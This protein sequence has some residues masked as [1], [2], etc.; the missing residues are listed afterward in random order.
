M[1]TFF[2]IIFSV[3][4]LTSCGNDN[5]RKISNDQDQTLTTVKE[6][7]NSYN[8]DKV[9]DGESDTITLVNV[10]SIMIKKYPIIQSFDTTNIKVIGHEDLN[11]ITATVKQEISGYSKESYMLIFHMNSKKPLIVAFTSDKCVINKSINEF[12]V[13]SKIKK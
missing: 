8:Y 13:N 1:K 4:L 5:N 12:K 9:I 11:L 7:I 3:I 2:F 10:E 6:V